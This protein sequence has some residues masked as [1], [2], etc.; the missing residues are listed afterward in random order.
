M[1]QDRWEGDPCPEAALTQGGVRP[2]PGVQLRASAALLG[3]VLFLGDK[4]AGALRLQGEGGLTVSPRVLAPS[5][6]GFA[7]GLPRRRLS[8]TRRCPG[9]AVTKCHPPG[10]VKPHSCVVTVVQA[11]RLRS[12]CRQGRLPLG[13][14][15][16][17]PCLVRPGFWGL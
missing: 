14:L 3:S 15:G 16:E 1:G 13:A 11:V 10:D 12:R 5:R 2:P 17:G 4:K 7:A 6:V 8:G 9:A